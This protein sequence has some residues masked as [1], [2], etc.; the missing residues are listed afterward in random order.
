MYGG[1]SLDTASIQAANGRVYVFHDYQ[2]TVID[3]N[4]SVL[5]TIANVSDPA[6]VDDRGYIYTVSPVKTDPV[7]E[8][9]VYDYRIPSSIVNAY[10]PDGN[11]SWSQDIGEP[12]IRQYVREDVRAAVRYSASLQGPEPVPAAQ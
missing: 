10:S 3:G 9:G 1:A 4:G 2:E 6:A 7:L 11:L 5:F 8:G 12:V